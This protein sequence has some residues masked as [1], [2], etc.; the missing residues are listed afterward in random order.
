MI[1]NSL[2]IAGQ[3]IIFL[4]IIAVIISVVISLVRKRTNSN[5]IVKDEN[6]DIRKIQ[7]EQNT[8]SLKI[9]K[10]RLAKGEITKEEFNKLKIE[11][12]T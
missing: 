11:F 9:L 4:I 7:E 8:N 3:E 6:V 12:E 10:E 1:S 2:Y 5:I